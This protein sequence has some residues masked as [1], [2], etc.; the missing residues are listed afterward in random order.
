MLS[1]TANKESGELKTL[2]HNAKRMILDADYDECYQMV[3]ASMSQY[4]NAPQPHNLLGILYEKESRHGEAMRQF[5]AALA[6][7]PGFRPA[8][9][10]LNTY[11]TFYA[12]GKCAFED[13]DCD[14]EESDGY[15]MVCAKTYVG[16]SYGQEELV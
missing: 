8:S 2:C 15:L 12:V 6:L 14:T 10:N 13:E 1:T 9:Q 4:P 5:R 7:D 16:R 11:G 3:C